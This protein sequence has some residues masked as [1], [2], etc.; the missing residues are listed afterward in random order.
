[1]SLLLFFRVAFDI[2][3]VFFL[4]GRTATFHIVRHISLVTRPAFLCVLKPK[5]ISE[6][7]ASK[8]PL[9]LRMLGLSTEYVYKRDGRVN[10]DVV[11]IYL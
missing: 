11:L 5:S 10:F 9:R 8:L 6:F 4:E 2:A 1:M 7:F 3:L